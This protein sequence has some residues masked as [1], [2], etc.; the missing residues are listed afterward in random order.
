MIMHINILRLKIMVEENLNDKLN[1]LI[2]I[3]IQNSEKE[4]N[5]LK[6]HWFFISCTISYFNGLYYMKS[7]I[8][9]ISNYKTKSLPKEYL[10][11]PK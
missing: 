10:I 6:G 11:I 1:D 3:E 2:N 7:V 4:T 5:D 8:N 9:R